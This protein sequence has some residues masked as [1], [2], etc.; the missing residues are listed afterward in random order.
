MVSV[1]V[2][3]NCVVSDVLQKERLEA[4]DYAGI[5]A[6]ARVLAKSK[7]S[8]TA[9]RKL[10]EFVTENCPANGEAWYRLAKVGMELELWTLAANAAF[11]A[12]SFG[13]RRPHAWVRRAYCMQKNGNFTGAVHS[14]LSG[15]AEDGLSYR[16][17]GM[18]NRGLRFLSE[19]G[20][21]V[22]NLSQYHPPL[23][24]R[25]IEFVTASTPSEFTA[26]LFATKEG[27]R[28][29]IVLLHND[30]E[31]SGVMPVEALAAACATALRR[32]EIVTTR[33]AEFM[34]LIEHHDAPAELR[35]IRF[36]ENKEGSPAYVDDAVNHYR[37]EDLT[38]YRLDFQI[39][40]RDW[41]ERQY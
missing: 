37:F 30:A 19:K 29:Y 25:R 38:G 40:A 6:R 8:R 23:A 3:Q 16:L 10:L 11:M 1:E 27:R 20:A 17:I 28:R 33:D 36:A 2:V 21:G 31:A 41:I 22:P 4:T 12:G 18:A 24:T 26:Q 14:Y 9:A 32:F 15:L 34:V 7:R 39:A 5:V 35:T 13:Y